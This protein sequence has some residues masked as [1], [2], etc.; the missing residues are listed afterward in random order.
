MSIEYKMYQNNNERSSAFKKW[1]ARPALKKGMS[2]RDLA[3]LIQQNVSAKVSDVYAVLMELPN[4][5]HLAFENGRPVSLEG[6]GTFRP[7]FGSYGVSDPNDFTALNLR[8]KRVIFTP[9]TTQS[10]VNLTRTVDGQTVTIQTRVRSKKLLQGI[11]YTEYDS[12]QSPRTKQTATTS[13]D[14]PQNP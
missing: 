1:F 2:T 6:L 4:A 7:S 13:G 10:D 11:Q 14:T 8:N 5:I 12:Y 3:D 9:E